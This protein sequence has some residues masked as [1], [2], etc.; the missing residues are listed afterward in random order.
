M[1]I[2]IEAEQSIRILSQSLTQVHDGECLYC[3]LVR[4]IEEFG[5]AGTHRFTERWRDAQPRHKPALVRWLQDNG[6][7]CCDCEV[8]MN[9]FSRGR[10]SQKHRR[11]QCESSYR[12]VAIDTY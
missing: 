12:A 3:Y 7:C 4:M 9:V 8:V 11:L 1:D 6:G 10:R 5:C 2:G